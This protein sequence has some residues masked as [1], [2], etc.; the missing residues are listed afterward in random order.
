MCMYIFTY[1]GELDISL[2]Y[3]SVS[4]G[5]LNIYPMVYIFAY[6]RGISSAFT[7]KIVLRLAFKVGHIKRPLNSHVSVW[8]IPT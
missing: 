8:K 6:N 1:G 5:L 4:S 7:F 2:I 3:A